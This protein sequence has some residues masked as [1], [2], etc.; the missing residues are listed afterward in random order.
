MA[1]WK[2]DKE[3]GGFLLHFEA[4]VLFELESGA[5]VLRECWF[6]VFGGPSG[7]EVRGDSIGANASLAE[8]LG[9]SRCEVRALL[10]DFVDGCFL[11]GVIPPAPSLEALDEGLCDDCGQEVSE[12]LC[13]TEL[14]SEIDCWGGR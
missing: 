3:I 13:D 9:V 7:R 10:E 1:C 4:S 6:E 5:S 12:C 11:H 2:L 8:D 14:Q